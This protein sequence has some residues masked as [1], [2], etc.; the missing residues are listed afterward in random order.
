MDELIEK[1]CICVERG[2]VNKSSP[3]PKDFLGN[4][5]PIN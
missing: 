1:I 2:K 5:V 4:M 3:Y